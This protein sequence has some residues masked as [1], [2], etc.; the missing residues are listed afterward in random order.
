MTLGQHSIPLF[1]YLCRWREALPAIAAACLLAALPRP[2]HPA[3]EAAPH[4]IEPVREWRLDDFTQ[5]YGV[6][7][8][9][10]AWGVRKFAPIFGNGDRYFFQFVHEGNTHEIVLKSGKDNSFS[11]GLDKTPFRV[12]AWPILEWEWKM[13]TL[14]QGGDV[15]V[16]ERDDQAGS[17]CV[18]V[19]P[20]LVGFKSLCYL[21]ES[22]GPKEQPI[23]SVQRGDSKYLILRTAKSGDP[24]GT[25]LKEHRNVL[26]DYTR[27]FGKAP[28]DEA[29]FGFQI[30]S[31]DTRSA[32]EAR[33]RNVYLRK[34]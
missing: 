20:G 31:N 32:A 14:P 16:K 24:V 28:D 19:N 6:R 30:D 11:V 22:D 25:W 2:A 21:F 5:T 23:T 33:Y 17:V 12:E 29:V 4:T 7:Q 15:R 1:G 9:Y 18:I 8:L 3:G 34:P 26:Q 13:V 27:L 10:G